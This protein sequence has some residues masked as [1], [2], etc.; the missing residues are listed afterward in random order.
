[1][2]QDELVFDGADYNHER[3]S[4]RLTGQLHRIFECMKDGKPRTLR[5][6]SHITGD[7]EPSVSAQLRGLRRPKFG[8]HTVEK[9]YIKNGLYKYRLIVNE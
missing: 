1:M 3:D 6:I 4:A 8:A 5:E 7:P 9:E 2:N